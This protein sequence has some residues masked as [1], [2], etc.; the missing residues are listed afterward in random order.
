M[1]KLVGLFM[2]IMPM[3]TFAQGGYPGMSE[4]DMQR[5]MQQLQNGMPNMEQ[6]QKGMACMQGMD[7]AGMESV[8]DKLKPRAEQM[9]SEVKALC[10]VGK[11]DEALT[12]GMAFYQ[13]IKANYPELESFRQRA[14]K[15]GEMLRGM[16]P[17]MPFMGYDDKKPSD[18]HIC[19][20]L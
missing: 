20:E 4:A 18:T 1:K 10:A 6:M 7:I 5:M 19:D 12:R 16:M 15:C 14:L 8:M 17:N 2:L 13:E 11:R 9:K 3:V